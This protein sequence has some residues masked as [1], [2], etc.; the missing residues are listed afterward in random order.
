MYYTQYLN[1]MPRTAQL[2]PSHVPDSVPARCVQPVCWS[3]MPVCT[4]HPPARLWG[5]RNRQPRQRP[6]TVGTPYLVPEKGKGMFLYSAVSSPLAR[7]K[8]FT[9]FLPWQTGSFRH[10]LGFSGKHSSHAAIMPEQWSL[11]FPPP[12]IARYWFIQLSGL[13]HHGEN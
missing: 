3:L 4:R 2:L 8:R 12:S 11:I 5:H 6:A 7:S 10:Q 13:R 1:T 9:H